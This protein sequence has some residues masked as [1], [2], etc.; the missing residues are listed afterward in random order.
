[1]MAFHRGEVERLREYLQRDPGL[2]E[3]RFSSREIYPPELGCANEGRSGM[4][5]T[6]IGGTTLLHLAIDFD[7]AEIFELLLESGADVNARATIDGDGFGGHT[8][9]FN[10]VVSC[11]YTNGRQRDASMVRTLLTRG[12]STTTRA[13]VRKFLD[14]RATPGWHEARNV[15]A[16]EWGRDFPERG[17]V[18]VEAMRLLGERAQ[19]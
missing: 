13:N 5:G 4:H 18:N 3:K 6:P 15:T 16:A 19:L 17:W 10:A 2:V 11:A 12:A 7:E 9:L 1:M 14:W 8:P